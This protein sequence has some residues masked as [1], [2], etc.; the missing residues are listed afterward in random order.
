MN[1]IKLTI[2]Y[3]GTNY[4]GWQK[5]KMGPSIEE[6]LEKALKQIL[7]HEIHLQAASRTD[8]GVHASGQV[9]NFFTPKTLHCSDKFLTG[10]NSLIPKDISVT[11]LELAGPNFH[12]TLD[13]QGKEYHYHLC[14]GRFQQPL[15]R[16]F[17]W[18]Y[19]HPLNVELMRKAAKMMLGEHDFKTFCNAKAE[20]ASYVR[21]IHSIDIVEV[22]ES[23]L[24]FEIYGKNF[25]YK[26]VRNIV[27][28]LIYIGCGKIDIQS[29]P[30]IL[31]GRCRTLA[32]V[33]APAHGLT[34]HKVVYASQV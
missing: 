11:Y 6:A 12:P 15:E 33:T 16:H 24:R 19:P 8:R 21:T 2:A 25:L 10:I 32:G 29:L 7:Q 23:H 13:C 26:M 9:V 17:S 5:T 27:G 18:H 30:D 20:Y 4:L 28:S 22:K 3:E 31:Q 1:N 34:L 14:F